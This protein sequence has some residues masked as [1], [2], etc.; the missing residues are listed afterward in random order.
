MSQCPNKNA[1]SMEGADTK[2]GI[3][4]P[5]F[6]MYMQSITPVS[7]FYE[8]NG[9]TLTKS[10]AQ[11]VYNHVPLKT[12]QFFYA[13]SHLTEFKNIGKAKNKLLLVQSLKN[14]WKFEKTGRKVYLY[15]FNFAHNFSYALRRANIG[16]CWTCHLVQ[17]SF[18]IIFRNAHW[19]AWWSYISCHAYLRA[20]NRINHK[21]L[22]KFKLLHTTARHHMYKSQEIT[23]FY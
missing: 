20:E 15:S 10:T 23:P 5:G 14:S 6:K 17:C 2:I 3:S 9:I 13:V 22:E 21:Q 12:Y 4:L 7:L 1:L 18:H 8:T 16:M 11:V 19:G